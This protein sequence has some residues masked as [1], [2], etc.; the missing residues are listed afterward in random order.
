[1]SVDTT[2]QIIYASATLVALVVTGMIW[3]YREKTES[4]LLAAYLF[5]AAIWAGS[6]FLATVIDDYAISVFFQN[7]LYVG[8][9]LVV[10]AAFLFALAYTGRERFVRPRTVGLLSIEPIIV[11]V[12]AFVNPRQLFY[13]TLEPDPTMPT[14]VG[15]EF[16][17]AFGLHTVYSYLLL[18][19]V[20]LLIIEMLYNSRSL[21]R[22]QAVALL[23]GIVF[24]SIANGIHVVGLVDIDTTPIGFTLAGVLYV[25]AIDRYRLID[26]TPIARDRVLDT[27][28]DGVFVVDRGDRVIDTNSAGR[29]MLANLEGSAIGARVESLFAE[30]PQL[31]DEYYDLTARPD[32]T[33]RELALMG[34]HFHVRTIPID[35]GRDRHVGWL[36]IVRDITECK[37]RE[38]QLEQQN[39]RLERFADVVSHD[40]RNPLTVADGYADLVRETGDLA[41]LDEVEDAHDRM[42]AIIDD[43][44][45]VA[46]EGAAVTD[47]ESVQLDE[48]AERAWANVDT[49]DATLSVDCSVTVLAD[50][51][52]LLRLLENLFRNAIE[53]GSPSD[54]P[55]ADESE[56]NEPIMERTD[57]AD[58][59]DSPVDAS[60]IVSVGV[61]GTNPSYGFYV[62]DD[63]CGLPTM[64]S[65]SSKRGTRPIRKGRASA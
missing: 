50:R 48:V 62:A 47:P 11:L 19:V 44:L 42:S 21:Y 40:L 15:F 61:I 60:L 57:T 49:A 16:G 24:P 20:S 28:T 31:R 13:A 37:R 30:H 43:V 27:V 54:R 41:H 55:M 53:H 59:D 33:T 12:L 6:L 7:L 39:E 14:G 64:Q 29:A 45:A 10:A 17:P 46:H 18:L 22:G 58:T 23:G 8:V 9:G 2:L 25:I 56:R 32:E 63:G 51:D 52:R 34:G 4:T 1:M 5:G 35:D 26:L 3:R 65:V 36:F 38:T